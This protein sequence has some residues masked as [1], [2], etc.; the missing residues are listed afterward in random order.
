MPFMISNNI[1]ITI[2]VRLLAVENLSQHYPRFQDKI[3]FFQIL[4]QNRL[5]VFRLEILN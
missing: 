3:R 5:S 2:M 4:F 1:R